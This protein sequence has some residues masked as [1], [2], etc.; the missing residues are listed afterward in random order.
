MDSKTIATLCRTVV[1]VPADIKASPGE[2]VSCEIGGLQ[3]GY[4]PCYWRIKQNRY[5]GGMDDLNEGLFSGEI[6]IPYFVDVLTKRESYEEK[7]F[8]IVGTKTMLDLG[9]K[10]WRMYCLERIASQLSNGEE[11]V[12]IKAEFIEAKQDKLIM[13]KSVSN[14]IS[15]YN[16]SAV[17]PALNTNTSTE[18][19]F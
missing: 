15:S 9:T 14:K 13:E 7:F 17:Y 12:R 11:R 5:W 1:R 3:G 6:T 18:V 19:P 16:L 8:R 4:L 2:A 10:W